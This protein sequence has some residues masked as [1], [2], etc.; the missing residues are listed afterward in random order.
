MVVVIFD[1]WFRNNCESNDDD[2]RGWRCILVRRSTSQTTDHRTTV[3]SATIGRRICLY[4]R[5]SSNF[6]IPWGAYLIL[7]P[8]SLLVL[9]PF[10]IKVIQFHALSL[11]WLSPKGEEWNRGNV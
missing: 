2:L 5:F 9:D 10:L 7:C 4:Y 8:N 11:L 1:L 6:S 3:E